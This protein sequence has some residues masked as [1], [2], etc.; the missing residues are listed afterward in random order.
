MYILLLLLLFWWIP[1][2]LFRNLKDVFTYNQIHLIFLR[3]RCIITMTSLGRHVDCNE[4]QSFL[5]R[6]ISYMYNII[7]KY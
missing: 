5:Y 4:G 7:S 3:R 2:I 1:F 6:I